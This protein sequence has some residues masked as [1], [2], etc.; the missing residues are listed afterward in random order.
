VLAQFG[1]QLQ[2]F[3]SSPSLLTAPAVITDRLL[4]AKVSADLRNMALPMQHTSNIRRRAVSSAVQAVVQ[5]NEAAFLDELQ[6]HRFLFEPL[7][8]AASSSDAHHVQVRD[9]DAFVGIVM[10]TDSV[11]AC[12]CQCGPAATLDIVS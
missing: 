2:H 10:Q 9:A 1:A 5:Q 4:R 7:Q 12:I 3:L 8:V 6:Q 11:Q